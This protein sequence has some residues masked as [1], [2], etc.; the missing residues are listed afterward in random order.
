MTTPSARPTHH[1][2]VNDDVSP[3]GKAGDLTPVY[4]TVGVIGAIA[5]LAGGCYYAGACSSVELAQVGD[6]AI[7]DA[8]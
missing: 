7:N 3:Y 1:I 8:L 6:S 5:L 4:I 2:E